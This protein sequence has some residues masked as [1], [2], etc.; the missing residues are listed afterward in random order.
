MDLRSENLWGCVFLKDEPLSFR[1][2]WGYDIAL[3]ELKPQKC[4]AC[5]VTPITL[6][7]TDLG[8]GTVL[9]AIGFGEQTTNGHLPR[10][11]QVIMVYVLLWDNCREYFRSL[12]K[13]EMCTTTLHSGEGICDGD[14]GGPLIMNNGAGHPVLQYGIIASK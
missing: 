5:T 10:Y 3:L 1:G 14:S 8:A 9:E 12:H 4:K 13:N 7:R 6:A 11:L 2:N